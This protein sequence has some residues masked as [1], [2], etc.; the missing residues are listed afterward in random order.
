MTIM[1]GEAPDAKEVKAV[2]TYLADMFDHVE[3]EVIDGKQSVY[4][5]LIAVE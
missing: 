5:Y 4:D 3:V 2:K 1:V